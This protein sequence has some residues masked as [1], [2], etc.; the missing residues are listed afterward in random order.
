MGE[1]FGRAELERIHEYAHYHGIC[2]PPRRV[3]QRKMAIVQS[4]HRRYQC[5]A[6]SARAQP[7]Q[8]FSNSNNSCLCSH[9]LEAMLVC[10][11]SPGF[12][13]VSVRAHRFTYGVGQAGVALEKAR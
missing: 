10:W 5:N 4:A 3:H 11:I 12:H 2:T 7:G 6:R 1:V 13:I 8:Y 9:A